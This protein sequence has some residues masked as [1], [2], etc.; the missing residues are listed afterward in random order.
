MYLRADVSVVAEAAFR[1]GLGVEPV[2]GTFRGA[3]VSEQSLRLLRQQ[4]DGAH[5]VPTNSLSPQTSPRILTR[6]VGQRHSVGV[7]VCE[8]R[9]DVVDQ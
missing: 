6:L 7:R 1:S 5:T 3:D 9:A 2:N 4:P 8:S